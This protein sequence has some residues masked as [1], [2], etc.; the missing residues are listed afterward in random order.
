[1]TPQGSLRDQDPTT[2]GEAALAELLPDPADCPAWD[3]LD[4]Y[5]WTT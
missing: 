4:D 2:D 3:D 5:E 1:M